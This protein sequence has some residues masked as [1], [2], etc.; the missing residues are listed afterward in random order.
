[1]ISA[2]DEQVLEILAIIQTCTDCTVSKEYLAATVFH[3]NDC[4]AERNARLCVAIL[5]ERGYPIVANHGYKMITTQEEAESYLNK[6]YHRIYKL[7]KK[8]DQL[9][10]QMKVKFGDGLNVCQL[11]DQPMLS[12]PILGK[13]KC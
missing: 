10:H 8:T 5:Q 7:T 2:T 11:P 9:Y 3:S 1:M 13:V 6:E 12:I 4:I